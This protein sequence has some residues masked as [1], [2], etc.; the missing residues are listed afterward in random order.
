ME[1]LN[2]TTASIVFVIVLDFIGK[3][4][5]FLGMK[6]NIICTKLFGIIIRSSLFPVLSAFPFPKLKLPFFITAYVVIILAVTMI[7]D[8]VAIANV[9]DVDGSIFF[10]KSQHLFVKSQVLHIG[11]LLQKFNFI[12]MHQ[13]VQPQKQR[14]PKPVYPYPRNCQEKN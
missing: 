12:K 6:L 1:Q 4:K 2:P 8:T 7:Y 14:I 5:M 13:F 11:R 9:K 3:Y 10:L